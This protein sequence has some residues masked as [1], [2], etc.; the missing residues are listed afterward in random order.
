MEPNKRVMRFH[1]IYCNIEFW[2]EK[3]HENLKKKRQK[4]MNIWQFRARKDKKKIGMLMKDWQST[5]E[6]GGWWEK[7][8][9]S[10]NRI[11]RDGMG[12]I[13]AHYATFSSWMLTECWMVHK[14]S[15]LKD[16]KIYDSRNNDENKSISF[17]IHRPA[18]RKSRP[19]F[20]IQISNKLS[21][22]QWKNDGFAFYTVFSSSFS[23]F[24]E[25]LNYPFM[26]RVQLRYWV[27]DAPSTH[28]HNAIPYAWRFF[29]CK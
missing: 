22:S 18:V 9:N 19:L 17:H 2:N 12:F 27:L 13:V 1:K 15:T 7:G 29:E 21:D 4:R 28:T 24:S 16:Y 5:I 20:W 14:C 10:M 6:F 23:S 26:V 25:T 11:F 3:S 8:A